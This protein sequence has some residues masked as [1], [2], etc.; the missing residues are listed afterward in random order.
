MGGGCRIARDD[1]GLGA[2]DVTVGDIDG[3]CRGRPDPPLQPDVETGGE[4]LGNA[5]HPQGR[6]ARSAADERFQ[7]HVEEA[8]RGGELGLQQDPGQEG[9]Q[10]PLHQRAIR[11]GPSQCLLGGHVGFAVKRCGGPDGPGDGVGAEAGRRH[12]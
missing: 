2:E 7:H 9:A 4:L 5:L 3:P 12:R 10:Y 8:P 1:H 6:D 11:T